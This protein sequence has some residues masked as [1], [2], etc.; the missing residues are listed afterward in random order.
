MVSVEEVQNF[1]LA[2]DAEVAVVYA[3]VV[4]GDTAV[5]EHSPVPEFELG[6]KLGLADIEKENV[7]EDNQAS[8]PD[9]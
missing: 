8:G 6:H 4:V 5:S 1:L 7:R 3:D 9:C 2:A